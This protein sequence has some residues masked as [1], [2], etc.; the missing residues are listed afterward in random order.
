MEAEIVY[1]K[2]FYARVVK[3]STPSRCLTPEELTS[4]NQHVSEKNCLLVKVQCQDSEDLKY[5]HLLMNDILDRAERTQVTNIV[6]CPYGHFTN[7]RGSKEILIAIFD[8]CE[9]QL[10]NHG[11]NVKRVH[12]GSQKAYGYDAQE[13]ILPTSRRSYPYIK[14]FYTTK[15][16]IKL[17]TNNSLVFFQEYQRNEASYV[18]SMIDHYTSIIDIGSGYGRSYEIIQPH[19]VEK[20]YVGIENNQEMYINAVKTTLS[21]P[22]HKVIFCD[23]L[24]LISLFPNQKN[25]VVLCLQNTIGVFA[26]STEKFLQMLGLF[27]R[28]PSNNACISFLKQSSLATEGVAFYESIKS[29][30]GDIDYQYS[31]FKT[32]TINMT[33]GYRS[34]WYSIEEV[35]KLLV[36]FNRTAVFEEHEHHFFLTFK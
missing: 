10:R 18:L 28:E 6:L 13:E 4:N 27:L 31:D 25:T 15:R 2:K 22:H 32:G 19:I 34:H 1:C 30:S 8:T 29:I 21:H 5:T 9:E 12:F 33:N 14:H 11:K 3:L 17:V 20:Q 26:G 24:K 36:H 35:R 16:Y 23:A 7:K